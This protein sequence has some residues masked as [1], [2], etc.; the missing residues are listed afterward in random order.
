MQYRKLQLKKLNETKLGLIILIIGII[1]GILFARIFKGFYW[2]Q[3]DLLDKN[4]LS[5]IKDY[6]IDYSV[7]LRYVIWKNFRTFI[8]F[9]ILSATAIGIPYMALCILY[10]G[11]QAGFFL[12]VILMQY[13]FKGILLLFGYTFP[14]YIIYI[15]VAVLCLRSG[16]WL[17]R[18]MYYDTRM[19]KKRRVERIA[20]HLVLIIIL[21][22]VLMLGCLLETYV[23]SFLLKK[24]LLLF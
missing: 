13:N 1:I 10:G 6:S 3:I 8:L 9:W 21:G 22:A 7:L 16:Y 14:H 23:G 19:S 2:D 4:Y 17:C 15:L 12:S 5:R 24:V 20:K 18:N 11:F